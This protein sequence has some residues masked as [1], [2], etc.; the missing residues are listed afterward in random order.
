MFVC[1]FVFC[2]EIYHTYVSTPNVVFNRYYPG[3]ALEVGMIVSLFDDV[4]TA[5][6]DHLRGH[7]TKA[8]NVSMVVDQSGQKIE[9]R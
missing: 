2:L 1:L 4:V 6:Y 3:T 5:Q 7:D 9:R 8:Q